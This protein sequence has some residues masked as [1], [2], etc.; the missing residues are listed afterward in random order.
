MA[1]TIEQRCTKQN[2]THAAATTAR[3]EGCFDLPRVRALAWF[4]RSL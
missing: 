1:R 2:E 4:E 3:T